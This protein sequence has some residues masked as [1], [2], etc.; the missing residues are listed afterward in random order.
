[1][2]IPALTRHT[3]SPDLAPEPTSS[4]IEEE[5][6][7]DQTTALTVRE[8]QQSSHQQGG[9]LSIDTKKSLLQ[10]VQEVKSLPSHQLAV[11][12]MK[13]QLAHMNR[14]SDRETCALTDAFIKQTEKVVELLNETYFQIVSETQVMQKNYQVIVQ[15]VLAM[16]IGSEGYR[17]KVEDAKVA[18]AFLKETCQSSREEVLANKDALVEMLEKDSSRVSH[19]TLEK[20]TQ[21]MQRRKDT[22]AG[23]ESTLKMINSQNSHEI[24]VALRLHDQQLKQQS[25]EALQLREEEKQ[26][27]E[28]KDQAERVALDIRK[29]AWQEHCD[30]ETAALE[31]Q[32]EEYARDERRQER[33][34]AEQREKRDHDFRV[35][36][37][38]IVSNAREAQ[39]QRDHEHLMRKTELENQPKKIVC[40]IC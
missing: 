21:L 17:S 7:L 35:H 40:V 6:V 28:A 8:V 10:I 4:P 22:L 23:L 27:L 12:Q 37:E 39:A 25:Q 26:K 19:Q 11:T 30:S 32:K 15:Q 16:P 24:E 9:E 1:M 38:T 5:V 31:R 33:Q 3:L 34:T 36:Q 18:F 13:D 2:A 20:A 14:E 29:Q